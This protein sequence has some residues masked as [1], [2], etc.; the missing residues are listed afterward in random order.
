MKKKA[1]GIVFSKKANM[2]GCYE[3]FNDTKKKDE[4][5]WFSTKKEAEEFLKKEDIDEN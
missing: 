5:K 1:K 4:V 3:C 2:W